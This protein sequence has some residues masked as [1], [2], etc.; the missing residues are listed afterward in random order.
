MFYNQTSRYNISR[1]EGNFK[2]ADMHYHDSYELYYLEAG[3]REYFV[4]DKLFSVAAGEF[5][6]IPPGKFHRT[7]GE[8]GMRTLIC[9]TESFLRETFSASAVRELLACFEKLKIVPSQSRQKT[10]RELLDKLCA[11]TEE[12]AIAL[13]LGLLLR[14][15][16]ACGSAEICGDMVGTIAAYINSNF[17]SIRSI[18]QI[19]EQFYIS[20]FHLCRIFKAGMKMTVVEYLNRVRIKNACNYLKKSSKSV[21]D[22]AALCGFQSSAYFCNVFRGYMGMPPTQYRK[23]S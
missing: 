13:H 7:G 16:D 20:K 15:L 10:C 9:F 2:M 3:S 6:L 22:I 17:S 18:A 21:E 8:Y 19:A 14:E 5:V 23:K 11:C 12:R 4:E 1:S